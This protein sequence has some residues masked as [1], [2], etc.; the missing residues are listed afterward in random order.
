MVRGALLLVDALAEGALHEV[1]GVRV[2][3]DGA[4]RVAA[5]LGQGQSDAHRRGGLADAAL[6][7]QHGGVVAALELAGD[8]AC[9]FV[10]FALPGA[11]SQVQAAAGQVVEGAAEAADR[12]GLLFADKEARGADEIREPGRS[13]PRPGWR[14][15]WRGPAGRARRERRP[16]PPAR[17]NGGTGARPLR[18][19][20]TPAQ[21][22]RA[23]LRRACS[24]K[25]AAGRAPGGR[26][27][28]AAGGSGAAGTCRITGTAPVAGLRSSAASAASAQ[29]LRR[30]GRGAAVGCRRR[31]R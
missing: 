23:P 17:P 6:E 27:R 1:A 24:S 29:E 31:R 19:R 20:A 10:L 28:R 11:R 8:A 4:R 25:S 13:G 30:G 26:R 21:S 3:V 12:P 2:G 14:S 7:A 22:P 18:R 16:A 5:V 15:G 9:E